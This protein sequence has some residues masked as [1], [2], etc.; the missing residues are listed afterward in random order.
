MR[1]AT[2]IPAPGDFASDAGAADPAL[3]DR[4]RWKAPAALNVDRPEV[5]FGDREVRAFR[6][7]PV[8]YDAMFRDSC[9]LHPE[10]EAVVCGERRYT[11]RALDAL[12]QRTATGLLVAGLQPGERIAVMLDNCAEFVVS[13][14]A[15]VRAGGIAV[16]LGTRLGPSDVG[17][18]MGNAEPAFVVMSPLYRAKFGGSQGVRRTFMVAASEHPSALNSS[19]ASFESLALA[20][21][22]R[23]MPV[24]ASEDTMMIIY[25]SGTTGKPKGACLTHVNFV[26]T[27][28][29]YLYAL[30][31]DKPQRS[32]LVV[33]ATHIAGFGPVL[34]VTLA[35]G[36]AVVL[37]REFKARTVLETLQRER[38]TYAVLVPS[39]YQL[40]VLNEHFAEYD[41]SRWMYGI[42]GGAIM[43]PAV[44]ERFAAM[45]PTLRMINAYGATETCAVCTIIPPELT[46]QAGSSVGLPLQCDDIVIVDADGNEVGTDVSGELLIRG[47]NVIPGYWRD[48]SSTAKAF[49]EGYWRSGDIGS[50]DAQGLIYVHDRL[51]DMINRGG[52]KVFSAEVEN[53]LL[54]HDAVVDCALVGVPDEVLGERSFAFVQCRVASEDNSPAPKLLKD[55]LLARIADYKV[56]DFWY[57]TTEAVPR[58]QNGKLQKDVIRKFALANMGAEARA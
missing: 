29:H 43:P 55:F 44:I 52:F 12:V 17:Y 41:L 2:G 16:P 13:I 6:D 49:H 14:L 40:C 10:A 18:I 38:I 28:L 7:R 48:E 25:T 46:R 50:R 24:L 47:P 32:L 30:Q 56:P 8:S 20:D 53:A 26:H 57:V 58:N 27:C 35:S 42:Y 4:S 51:K 31:I 36:G 5:L 21:A 9:A 23:P 15:C 1:A 34:S 19:E 33:P 22:D 37:M 54:A 11:Y 45:Q 39:M 3:Y